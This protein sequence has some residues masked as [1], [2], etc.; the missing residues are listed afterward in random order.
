MPRSTRISRARERRG[1]AD[2]RDV[3]AHPLAHAPCAA[4]PRLALGDVGELE[5]AAQPPVLGVGDGRRLEPAAREELLRLRHR[6]VG[7][8]RVWTGMNERAVTSAGSARR[9]ARRRRRPPAVCGAGAPGP[10]PSAASAEKA[11]R[12]AP[13]PRRARDRR[14]RRLAWPPPPNGWSAALRSTV[15]ARGCA[16]DD[17]ERLA[18]DGGGRAALAAPASAP[19]AAAASPRRP[20]RPR[21]PRPCGRRPSFG[22]RATWAR[23][24]SPCAA[25]NITSA[26]VSA[27]SSPSRPRARARS[28]AC[29]RARARSTGRAPARERRRARARR[30][31]ARRERARATAASAS[32]SATAAPPRARRGDA[33][34]K[35]TA[36]D[37]TRTS[38][39]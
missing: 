23:S 10:R 27:M 9:R 20:S 24:P 25:P 30:A 4:G 13:R 36:R 1:G 19:P 39:R 37:T 26:D 21:R 32:S 5:R 3:R 15:V 14:G 29:A 8:D 22:G 38:L 12:R 31:R 17:R 18:L 28:R 6:H 34:R 2:G 11:R 33:A 35:E 7:R 16:R